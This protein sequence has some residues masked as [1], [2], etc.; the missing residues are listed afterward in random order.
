MN[1][2][3]AGSAHLRV[4]TN[5]FL[6]V[7]AIFALALPIAAFTQDNPKPDP[8]TIE[9][10]HLMHA[11][12]Q[13]DINDILQAVR[14]TIGPRMKAYSDS[15]QSTI[16]VRGTPEELDEARKLVAELDKPIPLYKVTFTINQS[17]DGKRTGTQRYVLLTAMSQKVECKEGHRIP[18]T[19]GKPGSD[20]N[21]PEVQVQYID[22]G[23]SISATYAGSTLRAK[24][25]ESAV[26]D[27]KSNVGIQDPLIHQVTLS[28]DTTITLGK[29][30]I[31]GSL[32]IANSTRHRDVEVMVE[33]VP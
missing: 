27:E 32:D 20:S 1:T 25:E 7:A 6:K 15:T 30:A 23:M 16:I 5:R 33:R 21:S 12:Q 14:N 29:P 9:V 19:T 10:F 31:L 13:N 22:V 18:L 3:P 28:S 24:I 26:A 11:A 2:L 4:L 8:G 17:E